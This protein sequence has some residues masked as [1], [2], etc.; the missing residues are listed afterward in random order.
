MKTLI[1]LCKEDALLETLGYGP[2][3]KNE[4]FLEEL[5]EEA[6]I[7]ENVE[8]YISLNCDQITPIAN[9]DDLYHATL[10]ILCFHDTEMCQAVKQFL[11]GQLQLCSE[12]K[13]Q[14]NN[15]TELFFK[16]AYLEEYSKKAIENLP[17]VKSFLDGVRS[18]KSAKTKV[19]DL[20]FPRFDP[21]ETRAAL[22]DVQS[23]DICKFRYKKDLTFFEKESS[24][25]DNATDGP[26][27][28]SQNGITKT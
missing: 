4:A 24:F 12:F 10:S 16:M 5:I 20:L 15:L 17:E 23:C 27:R 18:S 21:S 3:R 25:S 28:A 6:K 2:L 26:P 9:H 1:R 13:L 8:K 19:L 22:F 7:N 11:I 14:S